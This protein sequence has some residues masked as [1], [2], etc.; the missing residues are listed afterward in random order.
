MGKAVC[1]ANHLPGRSS[2]P[3]VW[4]TLAMATLV[5]AMVG[6]VSASSIVPSGA[7]E[8]THLYVVNVHNN[9]LTEYP[10]GSHDNQAPTFT[11]KGPSTGIDGPQ[12]VALD[13][14]GDV[15]VVNAK[16]NSVTEY[17]KGAH[18]DVAP[19]TT[20]QGSNT[21]LDAPAGVVVSSAKTMFVANFLGNSV[22]EYSDA[23]TSNATGNVTPK[24]VIRSGL[25]GP[26]GVA[27]SSAGSS[28]GHLFVANS[29]NESVTEYVPGANGNAPTATISGASTGL[30][31]PVGVAVDSAGNLF[32]S[33]SANNTITEYARGANGDRAP[34][35]TI[36]GSATGLDGV[37]GVAVDSARNLFVAN[38][39][40]KKV[41][42]Y[43]RGSNGNK[44]PDSSISGSS[45]GIDS[46]WG[47]AVAPLPPTTIPGAPD[48]GRADP[49][50]QSATVTFTP[51][52]STG[53]L[54]IDSYS[55]R[56]DDLDNGAGS[57]TETGR[58]S[59]ITVHGLSNGDLYALSVSALNALGAGPYSARSNQVR[60]SVSSGVKGNGTNDKPYVADCDD[61]QNVDC[62]VSSFP[63]RTVPGL[64]SENPPA[65]KC[66]DNHPYLLDHNYA[67]TFT[68]LVSG[69]EVMGLGPIGISI[70][71]YTKT[72]KTLD[73]K[74]YNF[75]TGTT[76]GFPN[77]SAT[78]YNT[79]AK[80]YKII[81]HCTSNLSRAGH[82]HGQIL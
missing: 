20:I 18:G 73:G 58:G 40:S 46:P 34:I 10:E 66:P 6:I 76:T 75:Y 25:A 35:A 55:V 62:T 61:A 9:S 29:I 74:K 2:W 33:N 42:E 23:G 12:G 49:G 26:A 15:F 72:E 54:P 59:P 82:E 3:R 63:P 56:A 45:T 57:K 60:V 80:S 53:G 32:V 13:S 67:P 48:V 17:K 24:V 37:L 70:S 79:A 47:V 41:T 51:P 39:K 11:I 22:T 81:L 38:S 52:K 4:P 1:P 31:T 50:N 65:Y 14:E 21:G 28:A 77:S 27:L 43:I 19:S 30:H 64:S 36:G 16:G 68:H 5:V 78:N 71:G 69:V 7:A 8:P 44:A